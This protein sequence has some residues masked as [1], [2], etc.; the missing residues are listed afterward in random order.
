MEERCWLTIGVRGDSTCGE[1]TRYVH[2]R[3]CPVHADAAVAVLDAPAPA[4]YVAEWAAHL[5]RPAV[6]ERRRAHAAL[7]VRTGGEW[8]ALPPS[9]V[10]EVLPPAPL[11]SIPHRHRDRLLGIV[12]V[13]GELMACVS[14]GRVLGLAAPAGAPPVPARGR[15]LVVRHA[16]VRAVC[17]VDEVHGVQRFHEEEIRPLPATLAHATGR[18]ATG[19][20]AWGERSVGLIDETAFVDALRRSIA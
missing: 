3:N 6:A 2:C 19:L 4:S 20:L 11:H 14:L 5:A 9:I 13:R 1:L 16:S 10:S 7:V 12:N 8:L 15:L 17:P 18:F